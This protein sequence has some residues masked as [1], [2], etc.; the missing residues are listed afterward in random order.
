MKFSAPKR[1]LLDLLILYPNMTCYVVLIYPAYRV[2]S[3]PKNP[4]DGRRVLSRLSEII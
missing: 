4:V 3:H 1:T 2:E